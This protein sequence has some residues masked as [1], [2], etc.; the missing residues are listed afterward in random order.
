M[1]RSSLVVQA[2]AAL[3]PVLATGSTRAQVQW[4][5]VPALEGREGHGLAYDSARGVVVLYDSLLFQTWELRGNAWELRAV[6][7]PL[8]FPIENPI[9]YDSQRR[10]VVYF[11]GFY[12]WE[13]DG[14]AWSKVASTGPRYRRQAAMAYDP[15]RGRVVL[16]GGD[17]TAGPIDDLWEWDGV[18]WTEA[19]PALRPP[20]LYGHALAFDPVRQRMLL[21]GGDTGGFG[22][23]WAWDGTSWTRLSPA[24]A[25]SARQ[26]HAMA[27]DPVRGRVVLFGGRDQKPRSNDETWEWDGNNWQLVAVATSP[28]PRDR[29][30]MAFDAARGSI[31]MVGGVESGSLWG[32]LEADTWEW[33]GTAWA[34]I[35][36]TPPGRIGPGLAYD[37]ARGVT[38]LYGGGGLYV[39]PAVFDTW[40]WD[41]S[42]W[43]QRYPAASPMVF[44]PLLAHD[45]RRARTVLTNGAETWEWDGNSWQKATPV[46]N[47]PQR[48]YG[49]MAY[50][51][52]RGRCVL[53]GG[54]DNSSQVPRRHLGVGWHQLAA[55]HT[56]GDAFAARRPCARLRRSAPAHGV[57]RRLSRQCRDLGV[58]RQHV[59]A[60]TATDEPTG[61]GRGGDGL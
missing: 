44:A 61:A 53:F 27:T 34:L 33:N 59:G 18:S 51:A 46:R 26:Y 19:R 30:A 45:V 32:V 60:G 8:T 21:F 50:D 29:H 42:R 9:A 36:A 38:V 55:T 20:A 43:T 37:V 28:S 49:A 41:G 1:V 11:D 14:A 3:A 35:G 47:P 56:D 12:T 6:P 23:T 31:V 4:Q 13:Y 48:R 17:D 16:S 39:T 5:H 58:G 15:V 25:P 2:L 10:R 24:T 52:A 57:V 54:M 22:E 40:E 7:P